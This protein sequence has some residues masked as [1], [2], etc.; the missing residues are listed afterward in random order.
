MIHSYCLFF[1]IYILYMDNAT[2]CF[3]R[4]HQFCYGGQVGWVVGLLKLMG[5]DVEKI[6]CKVSLR[7]RTLIA[8]SQL[9]KKNNSTLSASLVFFLLFTTSY[10]FSCNFLL[11]SNC[12]KKLSYFLFMF[13]IRSIEIANT[14]GNK[15]PKLDTHKKKILY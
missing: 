5:T 13:I 9:C 12:M 15:K 8:Q 11:F 10:C 6:G 2:V 7:M 4:S 14:G 1:F 3:V